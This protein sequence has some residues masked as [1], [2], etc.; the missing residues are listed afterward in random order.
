VTDPNGKVYVIEF[1]KGEDSVHFATIAQL[2]RIANSWSER[3]GEQVTSVLLTSQVV[4]PSLSE[5]ADEVG[6]KVVESS[7]SESDQKAAESVIQVLQGTSN[8]AQ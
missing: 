6:V 2:E 4:R 1:K 5:L 7:D 3:E 8:S